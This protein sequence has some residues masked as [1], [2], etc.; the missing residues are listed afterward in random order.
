VGK[1]IGIG[2]AVVSILAI[3]FIGILYWLPGF[4]EATRDVA[5]V[6]LAFFQLIGTVL[7]VA[8]LFGM[9]YAV[10]AI[11]RAARLSLLPRVDA[12]T[13][14]V[15]ALVDQTQTIAGKV[16]ET[17][18][19]VSTTTGYVAEQVVSPVIRASGLLAGVRAAVS[20]LAHRDEA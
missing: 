9:L 8:L 2:L 20:Y 14:K 15:D 19:A 11:D 18:T 4:R 13:A 7:T 5:I 1:W 10:R 17:T 3:V 12:L 16:Q 6:I